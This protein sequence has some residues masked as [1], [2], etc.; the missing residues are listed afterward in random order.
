M[1][2]FLTILSFL[3]FCTIASAQATANFTASATIIQPI[4][5]STISN[6]NFASIDAKEGGDVIL[7]P[8]GERLVLGDVELSDG[9]VV[10]AASFEVI[11][12]PG[13][14]FSVSLPDSR[15]QL[16]NGSE[17]MVLKDFTSS[18]G[19]GDLST[20]KT[21]VKVGATLEIN[22]QQAPGFYSTPTPLL[23]TVNYN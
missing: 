16:I 2:I 7:T 12:Q 21:S 1:K 23:V 10:T 13:T 17:K 9:S 6:L 18:T 4:S 19:S 20:G 22:P 14:T 5:I 8:Q 15:S 3:F 11:G